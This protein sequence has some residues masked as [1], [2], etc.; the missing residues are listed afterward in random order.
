MARGGQ[1]KARSMMRFIFAF[2]LF[3][4]VVLAEECP[5]LSGGV[6]L[7]AVGDVLV[8]E[9]L[10]KIAIRHPNRFRFLWSQVEPVIRQADFAVANLEGP[11][12]PGTGAGGKSVR[13]PGMVYDG[14]VYSG[15][16]FVFNYHPRLLDDLLDSGF[17]L[18]TTANN[19]SLDRGAVGVDRTIAELTKRGL[20]FAGTRS[21]EL[22]LPAERIVRVK[23]LRLGIIACAEMTNGIPDR[24]AQVVKCGG[25]EVVK[26]IGRL[27]TNTDAVLVFP[28]W[29]EEYAAQPSSGQ[30]SMAR[31]WVAA[32]ADAVIGNHPHVLQ[33]VEWMPRPSG[34]EAPVIYSLGNFV[35]GMGRMDKRV[36]AI[37]HLDFAV[38]ARGASVVQFSYTPIL[39]P[40]GS[41]S[42]KSLAVG[43][44]YETEKA[45]ARRQL[46]AARCQR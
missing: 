12:A 13:D 14:V 37:A 34:G 36:A 20:D 38:D 3:P 44:G 17:D 1:L 42:L 2:V 9:A 10:F 33:T 4:T 27:K 46:G 6:R 21:R 35:A 19:H 16:N 28:H 32:G 23:G 11:T 18:V 22:D 24:H 29:G 40:T 5:R 25:D 8:H 31:R 26:T 45:H 7:S 43:T 30:R 41:A 15:T 39:R